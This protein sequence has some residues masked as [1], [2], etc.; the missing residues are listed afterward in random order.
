MNHSLSDLSTENNPSTIQLLQQR[1][2]SLKQEK[3]IL[4]ARIS[5]LN[6]QLSLI[7]ASSSSP[8]A[9]SRWLLF[10]SQEQLR[11]ICEYLL[12]KASTQAEE[13]SQ[14]ARDLNQLMKDNA[15]LVTQVK[16]A[17]ARSAFL[18]EKMGQSGDS[19][20]AKFLQRQLEITRDEKMMLQLQLDEEKALKDYS[21]TH[22]G[23]TLPELKSKQPITK[24]PLQVHVQK[25]APVANEDN[26]EATPH[27]PPRIP[28]P[29]LSI[30]NYAKMER[31]INVT[32]YKQ[33]NKESSLSMDD[34]QLPALPKLMQTGT[35][36]KS[37]KRKVDCWYC[38]SV[39]EAPDESRGE[40]KAYQ[41]TRNRN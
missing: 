29:Q 25:P 27:T 21:V 28:K 15:E 38:V 11:A 37:L 16:A 12:D 14:Q 36:D 4:S 17:E 41:T 24:R 5:R 32:G 30:S 35:G 13:A 3:E 40:G 39:I 19:E 20:V 31:S 10:P 33:K 8:A 7:P 18:L 22:T 34:L 23:S 9:S 2:Q 6:K 26:V 1:H